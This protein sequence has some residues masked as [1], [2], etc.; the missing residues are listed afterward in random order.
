M[1]F[2]GW[3]PLLLAAVT[4]LIY[5]PSLSSDFVYDARTEIFNE[6]FITSLSN[7]PDV[8]SFKV[9]GMN[10][11]LAGRPGALLYLMLIA[12]VCGKA[13]FGYH[14]CSNLLHAV[15]V[16]LLYVLLLRLARAEPTGLT[17]G[18]EGRIKLAVAAV[19][20]IF[21]W[22]P[23]AVE[24]VANISYSSDLLVTFFTLAALLAATAF[25]PDD[26]RGSAPTGCVG[27]LAAFCAVACKESGVAAAGLLIVYW[28]L[29]RRR[30][31]REPWL[32]FLGGATGVTL[33]FLAARFAFAAPNSD[34][35][36]FLGG[37]FS[38]V[39]LPQ[40]QLWVFM[41]GKLF[42]PVDL[43][44]DYAVIDLKCLSVPASLFVL[45]VVVSLQVWL[46]LKSRLGALGVAVY[47]LGLSTVSNFIPLYRILGD[48]FYYLPLAGLVIQLLA[49]LLIILR[50]REGFWGALAP[51]FVALLPLG[52][53]TVTREDVFANDFNLWSDTIQVNPYST[54]GHA[55]LA[56]ELWDR[57]QRDEAI[58]QYQMALEISP[59]VAEIHNNLGSALFQTGQVDAA[60]EQFHRTLEI[61]PSYVYTYYNLGEALLKKGK[62]NEARAEFEEALRLQPDFAAAQSALAKVEAMPD[63]APA[64]K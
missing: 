17:K 29:F 35:V 45:A 16:A 37:S 18:K 51:C 6:G 36:D 47:W 26:F 59:G 63:Q 19:T 14:L 57:G 21:A 33:A 5:W 64:S 22:H 42:W 60:I 46:A 52:L 41:M 28:F 15:N 50:F 20:L 62:R 1:L 54:I 10:L 39:I 31:K 7:L 12:A 40:S 61:R 13:P 32:C 24:P 8:L 30:E 48:R 55:K 4:F 34:H 49:L 43:S 2:Q 53:L 38:H 44:A 25:Q 56:D 3:V 11:M 27:A 58:G 9:L 23:L